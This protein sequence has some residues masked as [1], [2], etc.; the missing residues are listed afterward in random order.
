MLSVTRTSSYDH[1]VHRPWAVNTVYECVTTLFCYFLNT[2]TSTL[3]A[4]TRKYI[5]ETDYICSKTSFL[6]INLSLIQE[7][8]CTKRFRIFF[9]LEN[10]LQNRF[11]NCVT[12]R[13]KSKRIFYP[14]KLGFLDK[15]IRVYIFFLRVY[16]SRTRTK[17]SVLKADG[18]TGTGFFILLT[19]LVQPLIMLFI[20]TVSKYKMVVDRH[21]H[22][23]IF[24][25]ICL[26]NTWKLMFNTNNGGAADLLQM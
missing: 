22:A 4:S 1:D 16:M 9:N 21:Y 10:Y 17:Q 20:R 14:K 2:P 5:I 6:P 19:I 26:L 25:Q 13:F 18:Q 3:N 23:T 12:N 24:S 11:D 8:F 7:C 15:Y